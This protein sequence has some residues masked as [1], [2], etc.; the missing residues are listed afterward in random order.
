M[1]A[2]FMAKVA[3]YTE[4]LK[5]LHGKDSKRPISQRKDESIRQI[6][7]D[8]IVFALDCIARSDDSSARSSDSNRPSG[9]A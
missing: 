4:L 5:K 2:R 8:M 6:S 1:Y 9:I 7:T 3:T